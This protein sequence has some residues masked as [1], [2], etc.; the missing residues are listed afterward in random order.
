MNGNLE[1][2]SDKLTLKDHNPD[3]KEAQIDSMVSILEWIGQR[4]VFRMLRSITVSLGT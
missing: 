1:K 3:H 4:Y 2:G